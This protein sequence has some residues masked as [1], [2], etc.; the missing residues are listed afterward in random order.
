MKVPPVSRAPSTLASVNWAVGAQCGTDQSFS[1]VIME[2][3]KSGLNNTIRVQKENCGFCTTRLIQHLI[4]SHFHERV[5][6]RLNPK[7]DDFRVSFIH[8]SIALCRDCQCFTCTSF[9][10]SMWLKITQN[11]GPAHPPQLG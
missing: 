10:M 8:S 11:G 1:L 3:E 7:K 5:N 2:K 4:F 6:P 9:I